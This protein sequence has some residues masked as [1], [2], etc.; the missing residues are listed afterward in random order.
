MTKWTTTGGWPEKEKEETT[1]PVCDG[2]GTITEE[3]GRG[4]GFADYVCD[5]CGGTGKK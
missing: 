1:C 5:S 4:R 3:M 2:E